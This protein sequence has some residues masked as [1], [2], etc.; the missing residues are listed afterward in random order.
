[1]PETPVATP[2]PDTLPRRFADFETLG[3]ALGYAARGVRGL[4]FHDPRGRLTRAYTFAE[5]REDAV[6]AAWRL[7][8]EGVSPRDRV[9]IIAETGPDFAALFF[10]AIYA[11]AWPVP[12]PLP[13]SFGGR[14]SYIDQLLV[15]LKS[16]D[17]THLFY[18]AELAG[19]AAAAAEGAGVKGLDW[20]SFWTREAPEADL[21][22]ADP[23]EIAYLQYSSG[24]TRFPHGVAVTHRGLLNNLAAH[25][26]GM[27]VCDTDRCVS[28]LPWYHDMGLVG[29][30]LSP[31]AN[32]VSTDYL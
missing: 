14:D 21:P 13:T 18:P 4:N 16:A 30:L 17:P 8:A 23:D 6:R 28:W 29:C 1:M 27:H 26:H 7:I 22:E 12:L 24:S 15:Q 2:T 19:M 3:E 32:Q 25:S 10:G 20:E 9:A 31:V 11:G 5:L